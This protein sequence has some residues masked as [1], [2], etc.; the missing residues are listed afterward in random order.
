MKHIHLHLTIYIAILLG[1]PSCENEIPYT[2]EMKQPCLVMNALLEAGDDKT[3]EVFLYLST[4]DNLG[5]LNKD[6][7]LSLF[8][9]GRL[10]ETP[11][12][13]DPDKQVPPSGSYTENFGYKK[14]YFTTPLRPGDLVRLEATVQGGTLRATAEVQVPQP[15]QDFR[16][17]T[18]TVPLNMG[19]SIVTPHRRYLVAVNDIANENN[20]YR[21]DIRNQFLV[22]YHIYEYLR[23]EQGNFIEDEN[24]NLIYTERDSLSTQVYS[25]LVNRE[26]IILTDGNVSHSQEDEDNLMFPRIDY[27]NTYCTQSIHIRLLNLTA[28]YYRYLK[29]LNC[30]DDDDYDTTLMEPVSLP[31]NVNGGI[32]FV[33]I[34]TPCEVVITFTER[35]CKLINN[36]IP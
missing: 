13:A 22:R 10:A 7:A 33:G 20:H 19:S 25:D 3:N 18:C 8:I 35:P 30:L 11:Q 27:G 1:L 31:C 2:P 12:E 4:G 36:L 34:A 15:P 24:H 28:D 9:N 32:G 26:D 17:D 29:A 6:A 16:V 21:L 23:D 14:Y 5:K